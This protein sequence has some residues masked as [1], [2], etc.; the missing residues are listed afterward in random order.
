MT[1]TEAERG[2]VTIMIGRGEKRHRGTAVAT[3]SDPGS[4]WNRRRY[5]GLRFSCSCPNTRN[6]HARHS[7]RIIADGWDAAD[8]GAVTR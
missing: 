6:G 3:D 2:N 7:A 5:T 1:R 4:P 8:C